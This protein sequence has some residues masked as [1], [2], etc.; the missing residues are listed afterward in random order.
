MTS[1]FIYT[2]LI[3]SLLDPKLVDPGSTLIHVGVY[4]GC[5]IGMLS[6]LYGPLNN[7]IRW[8]KAVFTLHLKTTSQ[9]CIN[10][11][12]VFR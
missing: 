4:I 2:D 5:G 12:L 11:F 10:F 3:S 8:S 9:I 1:Y 6:S 7:S